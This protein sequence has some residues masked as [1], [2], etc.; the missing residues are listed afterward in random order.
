MFLLCDTKLLQTLV[1]T[2]LCQRELPF[3]LVSHPGI[4]RLP[5]FHFFCGGVNTWPVFLLAVIRL[6][7]KQDLSGLAVP[8]ST[9]KRWTPASGFLGTI[10]DEEKSIQT[11]CS[12]MI[13][14]G[15]K[16]GCT[17][18]I[19]AL[20]QENH[21]EFK[22]S[23]GY[24]VMLCLT[25]TTQNQEV[26]KRT[27]QVKALA[28]AWQPEFNPQAPLGRRRELIATGFPPSHLHVHIHINEANKQ[29]LKRINK[30][31]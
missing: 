9:E 1:Y 27:H 5:Q 7:E 15:Q 13:F 4:R 29:H 26:N 6:G 16:L 10:V 8:F 2:F 30:Q 25:H 20:G 22:A 14:F 21:F 31:Q 23:L 24:S 11:F 19:L 17:A 18:V 12:L 28:A 3:L